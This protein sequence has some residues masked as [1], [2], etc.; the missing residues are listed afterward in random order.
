MKQENLH[1]PNCI[2]TY[3][4]H[5]LD[6]FNPD[7]NKIT[8]LDIAHQLSGTARWN[9]ATEHTYTV[10]QH[11]LWM[12]S[13]FDNPHDKLTA[14][15]HDA[16]EAYLGDMSKPIKDR[17]PCFKE[18]EDSLMKVIAKKYGFLYPIPLNIHKADVDALNTEWEL[19]VL[20]GQDWASNAKYQFIETYNL[21][22]A[23][24]PSL[25]EVTR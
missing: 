7:P 25:P 11:S 14:L 16:S 4:G 3:S 24:I 1:E 6:P 10:A 22:R 2:R 18:L 23:Q 19:L 13:F 21:I 20:K 9:R 5:Y 17:L 8:I 15:L 12:A